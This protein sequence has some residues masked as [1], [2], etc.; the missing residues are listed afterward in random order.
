MSHGGAV[1][2]VSLWPL[3]PEGGSWALF[4]LT[5]QSCLAGIQ[6]WV[7][8]MSGLVQGGVSDPEYSE[9]LAP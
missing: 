6:T 9:L 5:P 7:P 2:I 3:E 8:A 1:Q 4:A